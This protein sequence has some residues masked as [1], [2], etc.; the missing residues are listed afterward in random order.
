MGKDK[1]GDAQLAPEGRNAPSPAASEK[2]PSLAPTRALNLTNPSDIADSKD[3]LGSSSDSKLTAHP[4]Q[5]KEEANRMADSENGLGQESKNDMG[6]SS[7]IHARN[8]RSTTAR[9][10]PP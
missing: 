8:H 5:C 9:K 6:G 1:T 10:Q 4:S 2:A 3:C 7:P